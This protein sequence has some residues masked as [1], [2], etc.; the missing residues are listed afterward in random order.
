[1]SGEF[2]QYCENYQIVA[3]CFLSHITHLFQS[4]DVSVFAPLVKVYKKRVYEY[5]M[6]G[7]VNVDKIT[8]LKLIYDARKKAISPHNI[9]SAWRKTGFISFKSSVVLDKL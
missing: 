1:V 7:A 2:I 4:L 5:N 9:A 3:V 8:F 6:F